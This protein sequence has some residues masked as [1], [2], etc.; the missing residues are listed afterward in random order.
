MS[1]PDRYGCE[2][3][4]RRLDDYVDRELSSGE[5][6][7]V[8]EH[9]ETCATCAAE[10]TFEHQLIACVRRKVQRIAMPKDLMTRISAKLS[11]GEDS[12]SSA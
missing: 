5:I 6:R 7:L 8:R 12:S 10:F 1:T 11:E 2:E 9:L 3:A 4:F